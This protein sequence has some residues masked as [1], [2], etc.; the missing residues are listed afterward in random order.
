MKY[1]LIIG[2]GYRDCKAKFDG[3]KKAPET[4]YPFVTK[5]KH[6]I[7]L[8]NNEYLL[9]DVAKENPNFDEIIK[10]IEQAKTKPILPPIIVEEPKLTSMDD[11]DVGDSNILEVINDEFEKDDDTHSK[12]KEERDKRWDE[13][14]EELKENEPESEVSEPEVVEE[15]VEE[16]PVIEEVVVE[17]VVIEP[18]PE[19]FEPEVEE[20]VVI[21]KPVNTPRGWH[22]RK[23]FVDEAGN[24]FE[25]GKFVGNEND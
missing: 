11:I 23:L 10:V 4:K 24:K 21:I 18:E 12:Y 15:V 7:A 17:E 20:E 25:K 19:I 14:V 8:A 9:T 22:A 16:E 13:I 2:N 1:I 5:V 6:L 3:L